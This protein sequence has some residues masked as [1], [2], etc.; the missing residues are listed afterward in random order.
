[1]KAGVRERTS[2]KLCTRASTHPSFIPRGSWVETFFGFLLLQPFLLLFLPLR[3]AFVPQLSKRSLYHVRA[4]ER[5]PFLPLFCFKKERERE[6]ER[7]VVC[8]FRAVNMLLGKV[9]PA[10]FSTRERRSLHEQGKKMTRKKET[11]GS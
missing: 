1:M 5:E 9:F 3:A 2:F 4:S 10:R 6:R 11:L 7:E 8:I